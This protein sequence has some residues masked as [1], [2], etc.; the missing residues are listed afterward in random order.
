MTQNRVSVA[1]KRARMT[2]HD[3]SKLTSIP[4]EVISRIE[5]GRAD[6]RIST[7]HKIA[8]ALNC[9]IDDLL[10]EKETPDANLPDP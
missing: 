4:R 2:Q 3:L 5:T 6:P 10:S 1:R 9:T 7:V 8:K